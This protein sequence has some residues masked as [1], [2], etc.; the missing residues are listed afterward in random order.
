MP[1]PRFK[2][3]PEERKMVEALSGYGVREDEIAQTLRDGIDPKTLRKH[4]RRE[5]DQGAAKANA[6]VAQTAYKM[7]ISGRHPAMTMFYLKC[8]AGWKEKTILE[9]SG[10]HGGPLEIE[11]HDEHIEQQL[12]AILAGTTRAASPSKV[13]QQP[14]R[15]G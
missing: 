9:H 11:N 5:L 1:R 2:P 4:F 10:P 15:E 14:E 6:A 7:A 3:T 8:R 13:S 12:A